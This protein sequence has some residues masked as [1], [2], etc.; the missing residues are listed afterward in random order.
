[1]PAI[2]S[3]RTGRERDDVPVDL[4]D[5]Y[6]T[7]SDLDGLTLHVGLPED[8]REGDIILSGARWPMMRRITGEPK[9]YVGTMRYLTWKVTRTDDIRIMGEHTFGATTPVTFFRKVPR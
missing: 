8:L 1:M 4:L 2:T 3:A 5:G 7:Y 9:V 6:V